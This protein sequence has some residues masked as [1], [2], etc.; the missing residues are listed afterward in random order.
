MNNANQSDLLHEGLKKCGKCNELKSLSEFAFS[1]IKKQIKA[2]MCKACTKDYNASYRKL[3]REKLL[4]E[5][6]EYYHTLNGL[7][8][9]IYSQQRKKSIHRNH[10]PPQYSKEELKEWMLKQSN[11]K[12]LWNNWVDSNYDTQLKPSVDRLEND[13]GYSFDNIELVT[14]EENNKRGNRDMRLGKI[15]HGTQPQIAVIQYSLSGEFINSFISISEAK[16]HLNRPYIKIK[17]ACERKPI[18]NKTNVDGS[19]SW[20]TYTTAGGFK[21]EYK[22][23]HHGE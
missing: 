17:Q 19:Q 8:S 2:S 7:I 21:W 15:I 16:R 18:K 4:K 11:F 5:K 13:K 12:E 3:H 1:S 22:N 10:T 9:K 6:R 14:W 23:K 20:T